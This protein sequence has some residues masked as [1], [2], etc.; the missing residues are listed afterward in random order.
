MKISQQV[1]RELKNSLIEKLNQ[2]N[3]TVE[4]ISSHKFESRDWADFYRVFPKLK[5]K[6]T[7][8]TV[9]PDVIAG[10]IVRQGSRMIDLSLATELTSLKNKSYETA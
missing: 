7:I 3:Q 10:F 8:N 1:K 9:D 4:V 5:G 2:E 6:K